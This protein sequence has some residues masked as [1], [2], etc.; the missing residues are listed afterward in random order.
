MQVNFPI[1]ALYFSGIRRIFFPD[2]FSSLVP[3]NHFV[4]NDCEGPRGIAYSL[5]RIDL[6]IFMK[7]T[8]VHGTAGE[9]IQIMHN[10]TLGEGGLL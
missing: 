8:K 4:T 2:F 10:I 5:P 9:S 1:D 7:F 6:F 3:C